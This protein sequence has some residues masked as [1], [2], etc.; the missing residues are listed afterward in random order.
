MTP[1]PRF[2][3]GLLEVPDSMLPPTFKREPGSNPVIGL[4]TDV[5]TNVITGTQYARI[6]LETPAQAAERM[7]R[8]ADSGR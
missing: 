7:L 6:D 1:E 2:Q 5:Y 3:L 8:E 4:V